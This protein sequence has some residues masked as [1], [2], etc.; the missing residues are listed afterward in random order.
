MQG[1]VYNFRFATTGFR[2]LKY[3]FGAKSQ[4]PAIPMHSTWNHEN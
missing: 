3:K 1:G 2:D 4:K